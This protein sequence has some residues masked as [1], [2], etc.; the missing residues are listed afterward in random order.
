MLMVDDMG[1]EVVKNPLKIDYTRGPGSVQTLNL[2]LGTRFGH[3]YYVLCIIISPSDYTVHTQVSSLDKNLN[4]TKLV[5][6][7]HLYFKSSDEVKYILNS[8]INI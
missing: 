3:Y 1:E 2:R 7:W 4:V 8:P 5:S 6:S